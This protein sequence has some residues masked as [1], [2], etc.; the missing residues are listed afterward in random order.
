M[1]VKIKNKIF[2]CTKE[3]IMLILGKQDK[4]NI[5]NMH[6]KAAKFCAYPDTYTVDQIE[7]FMEVRK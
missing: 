5:K 6:P 3:P 7:K 1:K 4:L 2:D